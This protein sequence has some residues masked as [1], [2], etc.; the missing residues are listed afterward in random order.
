[1]KFQFFILNLNKIDKPSARLI[2]RGKTET[3]K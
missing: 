1:M 2:K 3:Q